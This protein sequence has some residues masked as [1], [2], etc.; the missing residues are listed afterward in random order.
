MYLEILI[1]VCMYTYCKQRMM[2]YD[3]YN[4]D[5]YNDDYNDD[6]YN[7]NDTDNDDNSHNDTD[8]DHIFLYV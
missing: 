5:D 3:D 2:I 6:D 4:D 1:L 8:D 7:D